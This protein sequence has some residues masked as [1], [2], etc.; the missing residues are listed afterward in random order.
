MQQLRT[1]RQMMEMRQKNP[2]QPAESWRF[3]LDHAFVFELQTVGGLDL[4]DLADLNKPVLDKEGKPVLIQ[5]LDEE[6]LPVFEMDSTGKVL[7][8]P[9]F[10]DARSIVH[11][12]N[13]NPVMAP[14]PVMV[15]QTKLDMAMVYKL[16]Y[17]LS[18]TW[19]R[20]NSLTMSLEEFLGEL[21]DDFSAPY[22]MISSLFSQ[23]FGMGEQQAK[24]LA[25]ANE[26]NESAPPAPAP[27][28]VPIPEPVAP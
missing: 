15:P 23:A 20:T 14:R 25:K 12:A 18:C 26:G 24:N 5:E 7:L 19:R 17:H 3:C 28:P 9:E 1:A 13:G 6:G 22:R 4:A 10:D 21:P 8:F 27:P 11:D 2:N 16:C